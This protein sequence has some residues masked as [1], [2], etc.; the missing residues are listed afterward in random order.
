MQTLP[1]IESPIKSDFNNFYYYSQVFSNDE[2]SYLEQMVHENYTFSKGKVG[3]VEL[4]NLDSSVY[5]NRDI[6]YLP[7][8]NDTK[9]LYEKLEQLVVQANEALFN[10]SITNVTDLIHYVIYPENGGH[11]DWHMDIGKLGV[12]RRKLALT[13]QLSDPSEYDGGEFEVWFGGKDEFVEVPRQKGDVIIFPTFLMHRVKP[14][15]RGQRKALVFWTGGE[16]FR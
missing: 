7:P 16:P 11:L 10:F 15:I 9:W 8:N 4:G 3:T 14:I 5:N 6:A 2:I 13:V 12:N 1:T